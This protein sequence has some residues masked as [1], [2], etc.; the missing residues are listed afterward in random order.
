MRE[1]HGLSE[2]ESVNPLTATFVQVG[3]GIWIGL[4]R[5]ALPAESAQSTDDPA[6]LQAVIGAVRC[7]PM[8]HSSARACWM[9][10]HGP[11]CLVQTG[12]P[13]TRS[14]GLRQVARDTPC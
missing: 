6:N 11:S 4:C 13:C 2:K 5:K 12:A 1:R 9:L 7:N 14:H 3:G 10:G 8:R